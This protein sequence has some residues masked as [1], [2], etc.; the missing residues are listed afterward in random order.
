MKPPIGRRFCLPASVSGLRLDRAIYIALSEL[1]RKTSVREIKQAIDDQAL[2][3]N[4]HTVASGTQAQGGAQIVMGRCL[5][6]EFRPSPAY[7]RLQDVPVVAEWADLVAFDKPSGMAC[8]PLRTDELETLL[9]VAVAH[10][11]SLGQGPPLEG[12]LVH[13]LDQGTSGLVLFAR[14]EV[15]RTKMRGWF[16]SHEVI[17]QYLAV[18]QAPTKALP[19][20][21]QLPIRPFGGDRVQVGEG[22]GA[23]PCFTEFVS[24][25]LSKDRL[26]VTA[27]TRYGRRHQVRAHLAYLGAPIV[28]DAQYGGPP[29]DRLML[30]AYA[31][32]LPDGRSLRVQPTGFGHA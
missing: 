18:T 4:G 28:G 16:S 14:G 1:G 31:L 25:P 8:Q 24:S 10:D 29:G 7:N 2:W 21:I 15:A 13:R 27:T 11:P 6:S 20:G 12:G 32:Q 17:K 9:H 3:V 19:E 5:R 23:L 30:H 22:K 26:L